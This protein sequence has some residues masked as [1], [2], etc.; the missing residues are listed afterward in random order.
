MIESARLSW[1]DETNLLAHFSI[2]IFITHMYTYACGFE[3][4]LLITHED[5]LFY[6][7]S[8]SFIVYRLSPKSERLYAFT[9]LAPQIDR[10]RV[11][12]DSLAVFPTSTQWHGV[13]NASLGPYRI[14]L[15]CVKEHNILRQ[16]PSAVVMSGPAR[17]AEA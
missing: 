14:T 1:L 12:S 2:V 5:F 7:E 3:P 17:N 10:I 9:S 4:F 13:V 15:P 8:V 6:R 11:I 16:P